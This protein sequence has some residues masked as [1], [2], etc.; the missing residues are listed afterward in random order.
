MIRDFFRKKANKREAY[1]SKKFIYGLIC[2]GISA[3]LG[4]HTSA[5]NRECMVN[6]IN[7]IHYKSCEHLKM[8]EGIQTCKDS[9]P[10]NVEEST[11]EALTTI[12]KNACT[13]GCKKTC[14][15]CLSKE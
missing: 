2:C 6:Q 13:E 4:F 10:L 3:V 14:A 8:P 7:C 15:A 1:M 9:L 12:Y 11:P 5:D